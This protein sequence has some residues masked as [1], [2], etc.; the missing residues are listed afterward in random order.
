M[1]VLMATVVVGAGVLALLWR[2]HAVFPAAGAR[3]ELSEDDRQWAAKLAP[4]VEKLRPLHTRL[5]KPKPGEWRAGPGRGERGQTFREYLACRPVTPRGPR[6]TIYIQP[7]GAFSKT[8]RKIVT[9]TADFMGR[10]FNTPVTVQPDL[11]LSIIPARARRAHP[12]WGVK[13]ILTTYVLDSVLK[14]RLPKD[15]AAYIAFTPSDLWPGR[16]WNFV[17]GQASLRERVGV[18]SIHRNGDPDKDEASFRLCLLRTLKTATHE[19]GHM[20]SMRH[21]IAYEC[22]MCGS[23]HRAESDRRPVALCPEC[24][25]KVCWAARIAPV[26][27][28]RKLWAFCKASGLKPEAESYEKSIRALGGTPPKTPPRE[29]KA[30]ATMD[31]PDVGEVRPR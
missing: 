14:P 8:Q 4:V 30:A 18:W 17:F 20:F 15:A 24:V 26:R 29:G 23:N 28:Y 6:N 11:P 9:L 5:G 16:G 25:A 19:T 13:Q 21:C 12:S 2:A 1:L 10:Y 27:R 3:G 31:K 7:L 22:N